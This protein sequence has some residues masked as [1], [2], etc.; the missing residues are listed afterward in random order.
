MMEICIFRSSSDDEDTIISRSVSTNFADGT[1]RNSPRRVEKSAPRSASE[2][3]DLSRRLDRLNVSSV[4]HSDQE[5][6]ESSFAVRPAPSTTGLNSSRNSPFESD[7]K[8]TLNGKA[9]D[10]STAQR[11]GDEVIFQLSSVV[12]CSIDLPFNNVFTSVC[13]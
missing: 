6:L 3:I 7:R 13:F 4:L 12:F 8:T 9:N 1:G 5:D 11:N 2:A 10:N